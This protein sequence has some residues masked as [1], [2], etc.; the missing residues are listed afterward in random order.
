[1]KEKKL[2]TSV[3]ITAVVA[4]VVGFFGGSQYAKSSQPVAATDQAGARFGGGQFGGGQG[5]RRTFGGVVAGTVTAKDA[6][7]I[8]V[9]LPNGGGSRI[10]LYSGQTMVGKVAAGTMDDI[11]VG[12]TISANGTPNADGSVTAQNIQIRPLDFMRRASSTQNE[13]VAVY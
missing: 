13:G 10:I 8:T 2:L 9:S 6:T 3:I 1:M 7:S 4:L 11:Q 5:G 12:T